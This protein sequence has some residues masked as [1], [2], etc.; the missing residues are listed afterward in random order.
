MT[1]SSLL[2]YLH[3]LETRGQIHAPSFI[4][5]ENQNP[6]CL[7]TYK[8][9]DEPQVVFFLYSAQADTLFANEDER[10]LLIKIVAALQIP[11]KHIGI[12]ALHDWGFLPDLLEKTKNQNKVFL[13]NRLYQ[14]KT[15]FSIMLQEQE[16]IILIDD[17]A[18]MLIDP[19]AKRLAW[20]TLRYSSLISQKK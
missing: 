8:G 1:T 12:Y 17:L 18:T 3:W 20:D 2:A 14:K 13:I 19:S 9:A 7:F 4:A 15:A 16:K 11:W 6:S 5:P 10:Q